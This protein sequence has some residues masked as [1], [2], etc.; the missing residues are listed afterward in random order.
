LAAPVPAAPVPA[1]PVLAG[2]VLAGPA[3]VSDEGNEVFD[4]VK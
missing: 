4:T 1:G 3:A 2:L